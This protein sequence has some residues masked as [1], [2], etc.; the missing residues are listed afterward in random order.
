MSNTGSA[1]AITRARLSRQSADNNPDRIEI[2]KC[3]FLRRAENRS[4]QRKTSRSR[5]ENQQQTQPTYDMDP[6]NRTL[7]T[8]VGGE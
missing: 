6:G 8:L 1:N 7:V 5:D 2:G 3:W 4:T